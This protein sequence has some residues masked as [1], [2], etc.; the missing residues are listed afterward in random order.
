[1]LSPSRRGTSMALLGWQHLRVGWRQMSWCL[2]V[3]A[4]SWGAVGSPHAQGTGGDDS[5]L[6]FVLSITTKVGKPW[7]E[8]AD[9]LLQMVPH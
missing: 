3:S 9:G 6:S 7:Q 1:M 2:R 4:A 5:S 8:G